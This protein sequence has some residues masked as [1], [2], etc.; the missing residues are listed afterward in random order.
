MALG[1]LSEQLTPDKT[2]EKDKT[3]KE[4]FEVLLR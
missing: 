4:M 1:G 2:T 3:H